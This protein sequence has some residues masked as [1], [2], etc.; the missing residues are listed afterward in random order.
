MWEGSLRFSSLYNYQVGEIRCLGRRARVLFDQ[1]AHKLLEYKRWCPKYSY[2]WIFSRHLSFDLLD[3]DLFVNYSL[4]SSCLHSSSTSTRGAWRLLLLIT[5]L[6]SRFSKQR[7]TGQFAKLH[8]LK[9]PNISDSSSSH[10]LQRPW[11]AQTEGWTI[12]SF[13]RLHDLK[14]HTRVTHLQACG[15]P[16]SISTRRV[17]RNLY[18]YA[19]AVL[20]VCKEPEVL[21]SCSV[22]VWESWEQ[23]VRPKSR[24]DLHF[25]RYVWPFL[26]VSWLSTLDEGTKPSETSVRY[27]PFDHTLN[28]NSPGKKF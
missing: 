13:K 3:L 5:R 15:S 7:G 11:S 21:R 4:Y 2:I 9:W 8:R 1:D 24:T 25:K 19:L 16:T 14:G 27:I 26:V 22:C 28:L 23:K 6:R 10:F 18:I 20:N 12:R 17:W